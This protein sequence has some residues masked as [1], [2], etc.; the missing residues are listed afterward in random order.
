ME[1]AGKAALHS[2]HREILQ[3]GRKIL[4]VCG[5]LI[6]LHDFGK[7]YNVFYTKRHKIH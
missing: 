3:K 6:K 4:C 2:R 5:R 1:S 7:L